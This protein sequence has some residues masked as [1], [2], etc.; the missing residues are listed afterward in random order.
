[1]NM[2]MYMQHMT[3]AHTFKRRLKK[4]IHQRWFSDSR[5][6][7]NKENTPIPLVTLPSIQVN[8]H[9]V[10]ILI[11]TYDDEFVCCRWIIDALSESKM[12]DLKLIS[13]DTRSTSDLPT[14]RILKANPLFTD[15]LTSWSGKLSK[16]TW[17][18]KRSCRPSA[19]WN[20]KKMQEIVKNSVL[21]Q[22]YLAKRNTYKC[23]TVVCNRR[24]HFNRRKNLKKVYCSCWWIFCEM[25]CRRMKVELWS[26][27]SARAQSL[28]CQFS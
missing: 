7:W 3:P 26:A 4:T 8:V 16:P 28:T 6:T 14:H 2:C 17:P 9:H 20:R 18:A 5:F 24:S 21:E 22:H 27:V 12:K 10:C 11:L 23:S 15:L 25:R 1:M 19:P 13:P